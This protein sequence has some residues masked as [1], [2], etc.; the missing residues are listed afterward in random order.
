LFVFQ[1]LRAQQAR[2][3][4]KNRKLQRREKGV[5]EEVSRH[6]CSMAEYAEQMGRF[7]IAELDRQAGARLFSI[8]RTVSKVSNTSARWSWQA[9][10]RPSF[11][12]KC[13]VNP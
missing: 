5:S 6:H 7:V 1:A 4:K 13:Q 3:R 8:T 2:E 9:A 11:A 12:C 10:D